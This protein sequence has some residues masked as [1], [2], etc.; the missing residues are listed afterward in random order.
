MTVEPSELRTNSRIA[1]I[2]V[3]VEFF[4]EIAKARLQTGLRR[5]DKGYLLLARRLGFYVVVTRLRRDRQARTLLLQPARTPVTPVG[6]RL[7]I[8]RLAHQDRQFSYRTELLVDRNLLA[9]LLDTTVQNT[10]F[11]V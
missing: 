6:S 9:Y 1:W 11:A 3:P 8:L 7:K 10:N 2:R 5:S 4:R